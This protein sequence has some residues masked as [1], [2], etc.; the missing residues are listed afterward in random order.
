MLSPLSR[1]IFGRRR[2]CRFKFRLILLFPIAILMFKMSV[3][4]FEELKNEPYTKHEQTG[5]LEVNLAQSRNV[6]GEEQRLLDGN[7]KKRHTVA[8]D[9][10]LLGTFSIII[11]MCSTCLSLTKQWSDFT[12]RWHQ[13]TANIKQKPSNGMKG[14]LNC[15][16]VSPQHV[17]DLETYY[18][19]KY[20]A[21]YNPLKS[22]SLLSPPFCPYNATDPLW[23]AENCPQLDQ[24]TV[25]RTCKAKYS[26]TVMKA[27][28]ARMPEK[29]VKQLI[30]LCNTNQFDCKI[31][32]LVRDPRGI[33]PS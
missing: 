29:S 3:L 6:Y 7:V 11:Q 5:A 25:E 8:P 21:S 20:S 23:K 27:L 28:M 1:F 10:L 17:K 13:K 33:I 12:A 26:V 16:F 32:F 14:A 18:R 4:I 2:F 24:T 15:D 9:Q 31:I 30:E 22:M 19:K